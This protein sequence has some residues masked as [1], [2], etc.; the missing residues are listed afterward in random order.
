MHLKYCIYT[1]LP[2]SK[3]RHSVSHIYSTLL[4]MPAFLFRKLYNLPERRNSKLFSHFFPLGDRTGTLK[5]RW[6][7]SGA[8][9]TGGAQ[10][11]IKSFSSSCLAGPNDI[12]PWV[13]IPSSAK[14]YGLHVKTL[15]ECLTHGKHSGNTT[16]VLFI[17]LT[18]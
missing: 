10:A 8:G 16:S 11:W 3:F 1:V 2:G 18:L 17:F 15:G 12:I 9:Y 6:R 4:T 7:L 5:L 13:S 14:R